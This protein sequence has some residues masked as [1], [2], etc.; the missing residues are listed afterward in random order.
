MPA[1]T[2]QNISAPGFSSPFDYILSSAR[3]NAKLEGVGYAGDVTPQQAWALF[4]AGV[5][6]IVDVR[7][8]AELQRV[9]YVQD[10]AHVEWLS[11]PQMQKN[12]H[13]IS[14]FEQ[15]VKDD[16]VVLLLCRSGKR[17]VAAAEALTRSGYSNIF[18][19]LEDFEGDNDPLLGW[20]NHDLPVAHN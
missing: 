19:I 9:G 7:T 10:A 6:E 4:S 14:Q 17:S 16:E 11:G 13:F 15:T 2:I 1:A 18:N 20:L 12:Q 5:A 3:T 8:Y